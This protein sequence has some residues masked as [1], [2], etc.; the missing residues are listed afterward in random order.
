MNATTDYVIAALEKVFETAGIPRRIRSDHGVQWYATRGG[1]S[2][3]DMMCDGLGIRHD[4]AGI[5]TPEENGKVERFH[6]SIRKEA[7]LPDRA[8]LDE[9]DRIMREYRDFYN[10]ERPH[11][12]LGYRT[13]ERVYNKTYY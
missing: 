1:N 12:S 2:R 11:C 6:G 8:S 3:F 5:R 10:N 9:Y 7:G 4:M 13:P